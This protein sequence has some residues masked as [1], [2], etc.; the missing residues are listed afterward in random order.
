MQGSFIRHQSRSFQ[1]IKRLLAFGGIGIGLGLAVCSVPR[2]AAAQQAAANKTG[3]KQPMTPWGEP[4]L[5]GIW[6]L[7]HLISTPL[8]R[9]ERFGTRR[10]MTD[11]EFAAAQKS[12]EARNSRFESGAIPQADS[13]A[14]TRLTS[15]IVDPPNG[16]FPALTPKGKELL[17]KMKGSYKPG[18]TVFDTPEDFDSWDRCITRGLPVSMLPRNYNNGIRIMQ[19]PG[20]VLIV[21]EMAHETRIIPTTPRPQLEPAIKQWMGESRGHWEGNT[22]V[23][24]TGNFNGKPAMTNAGVPGSPPLTPS[25]ENMRFTERFTRTD[26]DTIDYKMTVEAPEILTSSWSVEYPMKLDNKY[27]MFEYACHEGNTAIRGYIETSRYERAHKANP[28]T[29][30]P[31]NPNPR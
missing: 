1:M 6:P 23:V 25:T 31:A 9:P 11:E 7:N 20:Y 10:Q 28:G 18:Q 19:S 30:A 13:G 24:Q 15:L 3:W 8:Q 17:D 21:L 5:Q 2:P 22:L 29:A 26:N 4:D 16:R 12:T 14:A 27:E